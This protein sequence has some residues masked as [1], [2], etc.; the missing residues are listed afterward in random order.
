MKRRDFLKGAS[1][2][3]A[4]AAAPAFGQPSAAK[5]LRVIHTSNLSSLDPIFTTAPG[6]RS[7]GFLTFDQLLAVDA[8]YVP[9]PQMAEGWSVED[10]G[11]SYVF[12]LR[13]GLQFHDGEPVR[14]Q[15]CVPSIQRWAA[16]D[17]FG[18]L[19][20]G[21]VDTMEVIDDR[22]FRIRLKKP[23]RLLPD[24]LAKSSGPSCLI[25]PERM[26][27]TDPLKQV[28]EC[29]GSGPYRFLPDEWV[30]GARAA[31]A[32][33]DGYVPRKEPVSDMAG[34]RIPA[35]DR[36][37]WSIIT[38]SSTAMAALQAGEQDY[39]DL[40]PADLMPVLAADPGVVMT[41]RIKLGAYEMLQF[42]HLQPPFSNPA[43]RQAI[44]MALDQADLLRS[45]ISDP[46]LMRVCHSIYPVGTPYW[47]ESGAEVLDVKSVEKAKAALKA[48]GYAGEKVVLLGFSD[49]SSGQAM[50]QYLEDLLKRIGM[51]VELVSL[52][53]AS[54]TQR[55]TNRGPVD[56]GGW[57]AF[58][59]GWTGADILNPG[60]NPLLRGGGT[61]TGW[62]GWADDPALEAL[63]DQWASAT[64]A[65]EQA[66]LATAIQVEAFK[67]LLYVP[68]GST[69]YYSAYRKNVTGVF[70]ST[71]STFWNI[72]KSA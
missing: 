48:A 6:T 5:T 13:E 35:V 47:S 64:D 54:M 50:S 27:K 25:M 29:V 40:V 62:F 1:L 38:E 8:N 58:I 68:L 43:V 63:R 60:V 56:Q 12:G 44:A 49:T 65:D 16:R 36:I 7:Y 4:G 26:A 3:V 14:S 32:K 37:E 70:P 57:S 34:G 31:W 10:D 52:D 71:Y 19:M 39:W 69:I 28:T 15:D 11:R 61:A 30:P 23:F 53:F 18:K 9:R 21:F 2:A 33:F 67:T 42:N 66:R 22:K 45:A 55:R 41:Q 17:G 24:A 46:A 20:M 72:G 51:S 59:T